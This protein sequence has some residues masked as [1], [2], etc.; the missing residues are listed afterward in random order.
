VIDAPVSTGALVYAPG[1]APAGW[2]WDFF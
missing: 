2:E 1:G